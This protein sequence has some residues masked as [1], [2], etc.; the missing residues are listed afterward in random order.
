VIWRAGTLHSRAFVYFYC[1]ASNPSAAILFDLAFRIT[2]GGA[3]SVRRAST[4][5]SE[6]RWHMGDVP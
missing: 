3:L 1:L 5:V 4:N 6:A 2:P